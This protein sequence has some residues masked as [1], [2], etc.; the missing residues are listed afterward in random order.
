MTYNESTTRPTRL[1]AAVIAIATTAAALVGA[2][3]PARATTSDPAT[4]VAAQKRLAT[5]VVKGL[6]RGETRIVDRAFQQDF[7]DHAVPGAANSGDLKKQ[8]RERH[9]A[10]PHA[11]ARVYRVLGEGDLV[12]VHSNLI[13][14]PDTRGFAVAD[15]YRFAGGRIVEHWG[16]TEEVPATTVSGND[17]FSTLSSPRRLSPDPKADPAQTRNAIFGLFDGLVNRKDLSAWDQFAQAPYYQHS[18]NTPNGIEAVKEVWGPLITDPTLTISLVNIVTD[19]DLIVA[20]D[21][22][23]K[24]GLKLLAFD[25][26]RVRNGKIVEHWDVLQNLP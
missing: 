25:I 21:V 1:A 9:R 20:Q 5:A 23:A 7:V 13:L 22:L 19:G 12:F 4:S 17:M 16:A 3:A 15:I 2:A 10:H 24:P 26:S 11:Q 6:A 18:V 14:D 8:V